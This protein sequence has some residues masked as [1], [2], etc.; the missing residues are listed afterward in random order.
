MNIPPNPF[1]PLREAFE[2]QIL[3][4]ELADSTVPGT[5][6]PRNVSR[7]NDVVLD[8]PHILV[9]IVA[10]TEI[11]CSAFQLL[12]VRRARDEFEMG[13]IIGLDGEEDE[14]DG[15]QG[16]P[17]YPRNML[18]FKL[19]DGHIEADAIEYRSL[20]ELE[21]G[22]TPLGYKMLLKNPI[23]RAG[24]LWLEP[25][26]VNLLGGMVEERAADQDSMF[27]AGLRERLG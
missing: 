21:L 17:K 5:G 11:G 4:S 25:G 3:S 22:E 19:S 6:L 16:K 10:L 23:I 26:N 27:L 24:M 1:E 13:G 14:I 15:A 18:R 8:G 7:M 20:P 2:H 12:Q 9:Q